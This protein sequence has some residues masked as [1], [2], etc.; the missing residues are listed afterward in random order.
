M[1]L[2]SAPT[3]CMMSGRLHRARYIVPQLARSGDWR[4]PHRSQLGAC[5]RLQAR[6]ESTLDLHLPS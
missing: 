5:L 3:A 2:A 1:S 4:L 6:M